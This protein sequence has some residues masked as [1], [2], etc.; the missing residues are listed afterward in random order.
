[1]T[2]HPFIP[3]TNTVKLELCYTYNSQ[4]TENVFYFTKTG[5]EPSVDD[6]T[7]F[8]GVVKDWWNTNM[9]PLTLNTMALRLIRVTDMTTENAPGI[10]YSTGLPLSGT[11]ASTSQPPNNVCVTVKW[12]TGLRGRSYRGRTYHMGFDGAAMSAANTIGNALVTSLQSAYR[13]LRTV[14]VGWEMV[15][16]SQMHAGSWR[17]SAVCTPI[18]DCGI[19][20]TVDSQRRRLPGRGE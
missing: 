10:E 4:K 13:L 15:V 16:V 9:K 7:T 18:L 1:M 14:D 8:A 6:M 12:V 5:G 2:T 3:A 20:A 17:A 19:D 11:I